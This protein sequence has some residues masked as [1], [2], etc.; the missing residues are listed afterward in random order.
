MLPDRIRLLAFA[1]AM[2]CPGS[3][4]AEVPG[5]ALA[6]T[7]AHDRLII[8][9]KT[10]VSDE[11]IA[12]VL[13]E[14]DIAVLK[15]LQPLRSRVIAVRPDRLS[16]IAEE[17]RRTEVFSVIEPDYVASIAGPDDPLYG[18]QWGVARISA[19]LAWSLT[20]GDGVIVAVID[21]GVDATH[22][23]L[24]GQVLAEGYDFVNADADPMDDHGHGTRMSGIVAALTGNGLG[25]VGVAPDAKL[26]PIKVLDEDGY[27]TYSEVASGILYAADHG[28][29]VLNLSLSGSSPSQ[30]LQN[31]VD[32]ATARGA[33]VV[34]AAGNYA[35][36]LPAYP[37]ASG[38]T[39]AV[40]AVDA[41]GA[42]PSFSNYGLWIDVAGPGVDI[43]TTSLG[44]TY[45]STTGTSPAAAFASGVFALLLAAEPALTPEKAV[46]RVQLGAT[47]L[48]LPGW[49]RYFGWGVVDAYGAL[50]PTYEPPHW[51]DTTPPEVEILS[52]SRGSLLSGLA[53]IDVAATDDAGV[54][55]VDLYVDEMWQGALA[56]PPYQFALDTTLFSPGRHALRAHAYDTSGN[57][58]SSRVCRVLTTPGAGLLI[59][60]AVVTP[61]AM[62][63]VA[64]AAIPGQHAFDPA[65]DDLAVTLWAAGSALF[66]VSADAGSMNAAGTA[67]YSTRVSPDTPAAGEARILLKRTKVSGQYVL[68][69]KGRDLAG[70]GAS[71]EEMTLVLEIG[72]AQMSQTV[73]F[74]TRGDVRSYR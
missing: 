56:E 36:S 69:L 20:T 1:V 8:H 10:G 49:D 9:A 63:V 41:G 46:E 7:Q 47:D 29:R 5:P 59:H 28:A 27:G 40:S 62:R 71:A 18:D 74:E 58:D 50:I 13:L 39:V 37:A 24:A 55:H 25:G 35:S 2:L 73:R 42:H 51:P 64:T 12:Q 19:P 4:A 61:T 6:A 60:R 66:A 15:V 44:G 38:D 52:P 22:P 23:D 67:R 26:L 11:R 70:L 30:V 43:V 48:G 54:R 3:L 31:A 14:R 16:A 45:A 68:R 57:V 33:V 53:G 72:G 32:Y 65:V 34:A 17:L 21:T